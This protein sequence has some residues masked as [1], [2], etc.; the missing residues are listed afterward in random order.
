MPGRRSFAPTVRRIAA[1]VALLSLVI[2]IMSCGD[3]P[4]PETDT[5]AAKVTPAA[6]ATTVAPVVGTSLPEPEPEP[7]TTPTTEPFPSRDVLNYLEDLQGIAVRVGE[8]V[9]D[10]RAANND[11]DNRSETGVTYRDT[12]TRLE[13]IER[14]AL[15]LR[16]D[17]GLIEPPPDRGLPVEHQTAWLALGQMADAAV[18]AL[19]GFRSPDTVH[20]ERPALTE[21]LTAYERFVG[22]FDRTVEIIGVGAGVSLPT[23]GTTV[24]QPTTTTEAETTT[25]TESETTTTTERET[26]D[27]TEG[28]TTTTEI[29]QNTVPPTPDVGY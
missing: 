23:T 7:P 5:S 16:D 20:R 21:F 11:W 10:M 4:E 2:A 18:D 29:G 17:I 24:A 8:L 27:T 12:E 6:P 19:A 15:A 9:V 26:T 22:A 14:R 28:E 1:L 3:D 25:T 13:D